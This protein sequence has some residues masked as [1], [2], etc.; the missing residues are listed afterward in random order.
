MTDKKNYQLTFAAIE[1]QFGAE[2]AKSFKS[3]AIG[4]MVL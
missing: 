2:L 1:T 4:A 3:K